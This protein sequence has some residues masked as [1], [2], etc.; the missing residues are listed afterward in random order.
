MNNASTKALS[1]SRYYGQYSGNCAVRLDV[2]KSMLSCWKSVIISLNKFWF[3][4]HSYLSEKVCDVQS[5]STF[6]FPAMCNGEAQM[7]CVIHHSQISIQVCSVKEIW[8][9][10]VVNIWHS[11]CIIYWDPNMSDMGLTTKWIWCKKCCF[12]FQDAYVVDGIN[13]VFLFLYLGYWK[14]FSNNSS[15][16]LLQYLLSFKL[17]ALRAELIVCATALL[18]IV[19]INFIQ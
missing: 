9:P 6:N 4:T 14:Y 11:C 8:I 7:F 15:Y 10:Y 3:S 12:E 17:H 5:T 18:A 16:D 2:N 1:K 19:A 13:N